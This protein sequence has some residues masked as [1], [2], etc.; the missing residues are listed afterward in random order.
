MESSCDSTGSFEGYTNAGD[1]DFVVIKLNSSGALQWQTGTSGTDFVRD[2]QVES[3]ED[4]VLAGHS[5]GSLGGYTNA[6]DWD[7]VFMKLNSSGALQWTFQIGTSAT[8]NLRAVQVETS[9]NIVVA[10]HSEQGLQGQT[11]AGGYDMV[12][13]ELNSQGTLLWLF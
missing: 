2:A 5:T 13:M 4:I 6:G 9:G 10:G 11:S 1:W 7:F 8:D 12:I 3:S